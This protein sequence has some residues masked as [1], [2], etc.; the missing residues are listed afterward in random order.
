MPTESSTPPEFTALSRLIS[1]PLISSSLATISET[2]ASNAYTRSP[3]ST[4][5]GI[6]TSAYK[7]AEPIQLRFAPLIV[8]ADGYAN[9]AVD[10]VESKYPR[11]FT[12]KPEEVASFVRERRAS[13]SKV[14]DEKVRQPAFHVAQGI[15]Q[16][17]APIMNYVEGAYTKINPDSRPS[18]PESTQY[19]YQR[20]LALSRSVYGYSAEQV[21]QFQEHSA[22]V[23]KAME[24]S[25][26]MSALASTSITSAKTRV[27]TLS[28]TLLAELEKVQ[29]STAAMASSIQT[30]A[31]TTLHNSTTQLQSRFPPGAQEMYT[32]VSQKLG[33]TIN[34]L[35]TIMLTKDL[36]V[37]EKVGKMTH[38][39]SVTVSPMLESLR[40]SVSDLLA[41]GRAAAASAEP[42]PM[43]NGV[44]GHAQ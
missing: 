38:E 14:I 9:K 12:T 5:K 27:H 41:R 34:D 3:Y 2:L 26:N 1:I 18:S 11:A 16:Q 25:Q 13:A 35:R 33:T 31:T 29:S 40:T 17:F 39:V 36:S 44:N 23:K 28:E 4:A 32:D 6:S 8:R 30:S 43:V 19:Q 7:Y 10:V 20:A 42:A 21:K 15:D 22:L 37:Q 24:T